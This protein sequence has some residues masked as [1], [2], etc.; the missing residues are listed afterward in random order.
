MS[1]FANDIQDRLWDLFVYVE[2]YLDA[3]PEMAGS[4]LHIAYWKVDRL[5][6]RHKPVTVEAVM[7]SI[8]SE[9]PT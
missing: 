3:H 7:K 5:L 8:K 2:K 1:N 4:D 9:D 6:P